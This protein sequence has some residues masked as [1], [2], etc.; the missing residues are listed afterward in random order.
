M[1]TRAITRV[2]ESDALCAADIAGIKALFEANY[3]C[4]N[5][6][7]LGRSFTKLRYTAM[8][9]VDGRMVGF[10]VGDAMRTELAR[11]EGPQGVAMAG[12]ACIDPEHRRRGLFTSLS[13]AAMA[14]SGAV[15]ERD[16]LLFS[17]R[18]AHPITYRTMLHR[19]AG[20]VPRGGVE[21]SDWH[22]EIGLQVAAL[23]DVTIDP[24]TFVVRGAGEP[25]GFPRLSYQPTPEQEQL[26]RRVDRS[27]GDSLLA[28]SWMPTAP[29]GW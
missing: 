3:D 13:F 2:V 22:K 19:A 29:E 15:N 27:R 25:I 24:E 14:A 28:I 26:F 5:H 9:E 16:R 20:A 11:C 23:F 10:A 21:L 8:A 6:A 4:A 1:Q 12:I 17:G 18:M 7:Y